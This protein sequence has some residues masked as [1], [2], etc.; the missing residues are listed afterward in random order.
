MNSVFMVIS[1]L[2]IFLLDKSTA[3]KYY[4]Y[5]VACFVLGS[6]QPRKSQDQIFRS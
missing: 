1:V 4:A 2:V 6:I 3:N 5:P